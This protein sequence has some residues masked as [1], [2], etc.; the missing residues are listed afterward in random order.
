MPVSLLTGQ[1]CRDTFWLKQQL[2]LD[3]GVMHIMPAF[4]P[5]G[6]YFFPSFSLPHWHCNSVYRTYFFGL[7][8]L[9]YILLSEY[10]SYNHLSF[11][12]SQFN[13]TPIWSLR[14]VFKA[15]VNS[16]SLFIAHS[17]HIAPNKMDGLFMPECGLCF[18]KTFQFHSHAIVLE[19]WSHYRSS[20]TNL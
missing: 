3:K 5:I 8:F 18:P 9:N 16:L 19:F 12:L 2:S 13:M 17:A 10:E 15:F 4:L 6:D 7:K 1:V 20:L 14:L 11:S